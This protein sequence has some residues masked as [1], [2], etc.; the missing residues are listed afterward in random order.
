[1]LK[2]ICYVFK[3]IWNDE[4]LKYYLFISAIIIICTIL[5]VSFSHAET[6][7]TCVVEC[8]TDV[9]YISECIEDERNYWYSN[10]SDSTHRRTCIDL[11]RNER[12]DCYS[13][14][15]KEE[16]KINYP[17]DFYDIHVKNFPNTNE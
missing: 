4:S 8:K 17:V 14:C 10:K 3:F 9:M 11:I 1:M 12:E 7:D 2:K 15:A 6:F 16:V 5:Y 13:L